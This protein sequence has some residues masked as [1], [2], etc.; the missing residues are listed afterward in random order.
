MY[1]SCVK[2]TKVKNKGEEERHI[3]G[4]S[5]A[6][7]KLMY[8]GKVMDLLGF[9]PAVPDAGILPRHIPEH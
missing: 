4:V 9:Q 1:L 2:D 8:K 3:C 6:C 7:G 5:E